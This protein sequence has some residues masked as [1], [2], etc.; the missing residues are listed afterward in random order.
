[1]GIETIVGGVSLLSGVAGAGRQSASLKASAAKEREI[2]E[3]NSRLIQYNSESRANKVH[4]DTDSQ[5]QALERNRVLDGINSES[6]INAQDEAQQQQTSKDTAQ[7]F[8]TVGDAQNPTG[9]I[10]L[11]QQRSK[12]IL[13]RQSALVT[14]RYKDS[15]NLYQQSS[16]REQGSE[17]AFNERQQ[18][19]FQ[20]AASSAP[21]FA[22]AA[23][24]EKEADGT[25]SSALFGGIGNLATGPVGKFL[26]VQSIFGDGGGASPPLFTPGIT[27]TYAQSG[28]GSLTEFNPFSR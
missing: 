23:Q 25:F 20:S 12:N 9:E 18:G 5:V 15:L 10:A 19:V 14:Q 11:A 3:Y 21:A 24:K 27:S 28:G 22:S 6:Q 13:Q 4:F 8:G 17:A 16:L 2:A 26:G 1:M 7:L